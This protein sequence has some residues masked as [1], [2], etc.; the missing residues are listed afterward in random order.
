MD[1]GF[2]KKRDI[3]KFKLCTVFRWLTAGK[4]HAAENYLIKQSGGSA[5][6]T[7]RTDD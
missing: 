5:Y 2:L 7:G 6:G 3:R 4:C 1:G